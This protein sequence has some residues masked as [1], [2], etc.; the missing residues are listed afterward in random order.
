MPR[1][2]KEEAPKKVGRPAKKATREESEDEEIIEDVIPKKGGKKANV[3]SKKTT[4]TSKKSTKK[5]EEEDEDED[6]LSEIDIDDDSET[7]NASG[8]SNDSNESNETGPS[9]ENDEVI[10]TD[11]QS[12]HNHHQ[13]YHQ[14]LNL[15]LN[16]NHGNH[17]NHAHHENHLDRGGADRE[18]RTFQP[19]RIVDPKTP[20]GQLNIEDILTHL[21]KV[22][23]DTLNPQLKYGAI[24][25]INQLTG[26]RRTG[27]NGL[28]GNK[29]NFQR[30]GFG[31]AP[32]GFRARGRGGQGGQ[33]GIGGLGRLNQNDGEQSGGMDDIYAETTKRHRTNNSVE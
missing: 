29:N 24:N 21:I 1:V 10:N 28:N 9:D 30:G 11:I 7:S 6:S 19:R 13:N 12:D 15:N 8:L 3:L 4:T 2:K 14:N 20:I 17:G 22:G 32:N 31:A 16:H 23:S 5:V 25:L 27:G 26:R 33:G 18:S